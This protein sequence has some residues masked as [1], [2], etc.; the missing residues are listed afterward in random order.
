MSVRIEKSVFSFVV[1]FNKSGR[2]SSLSTKPR[3]ENA[4]TTSRSRDENNS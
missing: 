4:G 1:F 3:Q 2:T